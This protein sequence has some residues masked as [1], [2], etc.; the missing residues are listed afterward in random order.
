MGILEF[1]QKTKNLN[2]NPTVEIVEN[3]IKEFLDII[4]NNFDPNTRID[5]RI[6]D[7]EI[8]NAYSNSLIYLFNWI[9]KTRDN[10]LYYI[11]F[12]FISDKFQPFIRRKISYSINRRIY[13]CIDTLLN[14]LGSKLF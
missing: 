10:D 11:L 8:Q 5:N 12:C 1:Y 14:I 6:E 13:N 2:C 4:E 7:I 9:T 3:N